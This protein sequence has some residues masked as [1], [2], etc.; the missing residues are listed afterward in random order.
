M[1]G[2]LL[3]VPGLAR[4]QYIFKPID[5]PGALWTGATGNSTHE[6]VGE[7]AV[8]EDVDNAVLHGFVLNKGVF[9]TVDVTELGA[10]QTSVNGINAS[11]QL[12]GSYMDK[13]ASGNDRFHAY[14][15][16]KGD[17]RNI[18]FPGSIRSVGGFINAQGEAVGTYRDPSQKRHGFIWRKGAF[19]PPINVPGDHPF[20][21]TVAI[22]INDLG[23]VVG[24]FVD[25]DDKGVPP[26]PAEHRH[27]FLR[28]SK[29]EITR[30]DVPVTNSK[31]ADS[32]TAEG[33][34]NAGTI[35]GWYAVDGLAHGFVLSKG[36]FTTVDVDVPNATATQIRSINAKGEIVGVYFD[37]AGI[38][39][40]FLGTPIR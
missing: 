33:I 35:V 14:V 18:D 20:Y 1:L 7:F 26:G 23:Q 27:G 21:G 37:G 15:G 17:F 19:T 6:I 36:V 40:G 12:E 9:T 11:G 34:N 16:K 38:Q 22:G 2:L 24:D 32:T 13:D 30:F 8:G 3:S 29:G 10:L 28:S 25:K 39:H 31:V 5:V 4:A